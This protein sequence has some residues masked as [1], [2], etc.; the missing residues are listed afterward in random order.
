[1]RKAVRDRG[2]LEAKAVADRK[3]DDGN[4]IVDL[5]VRFD[6]GPQYHMGKLTINGLDIEG[7]N[8]MLRIW[9][10]K[11]GNPFDPDYPDHFLDVVRKEGIFDHL[12][13]TRAS[14]QVDEKTHTAAVELFFTGDG[15][16]KKKKR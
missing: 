8:E 7:E 13:K 4:K 11:T 3:M 2:Y 1:M 10:M 5:I 15:I 12:G 6:S 16:T 9:T 14:L